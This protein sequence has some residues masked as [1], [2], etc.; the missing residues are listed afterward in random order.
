MGNSILEL[1][2]AHQVK[3]WKG[4]NNI[5]SNRN[6]QLMDSNCCMCGR[7]MTVKKWENK[8]HYCYKCH[9]EAEAVFQDY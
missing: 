7:A 9:D 5:N 3:C 2:K 8:P 1:A 6:L 4:R